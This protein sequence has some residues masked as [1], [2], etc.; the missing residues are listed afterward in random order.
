MDRRQEEQEQESQYRLSPHNNDDDDDGLVVALSGQ[1][2][3]LFSKI[4]RVGRSRSS[5]YDED[6]LSSILL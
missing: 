5:S 4:P 2:R 3:N 6:R 1:R